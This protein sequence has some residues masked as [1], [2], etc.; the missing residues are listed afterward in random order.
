MSLFRQLADLQDDIV[1][2]R[3]TIR[4]CE[5]R[6]LRKEIAMAE[7]VS[8]HECRVEESGV[9]TMPA[10]KAVPPPAPV[11]A[12]P[13]PKR[14]YSEE[15]RAKQSATMKKIWEQRKQSRVWVTSLSATPAISLLTALSRN[16]ERNHTNPPIKTPV[17]ES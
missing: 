12:P 9:V 3:A 14:I 8:G 17:I 5:N 13:K 2:L 16:G 4:Y 6:I 11:S 10:E 15:A 7:L 1:N